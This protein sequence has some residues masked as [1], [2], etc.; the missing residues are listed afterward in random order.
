MGP[1][2]SAHLLEPGAERRQPLGP[3]FLAES[4]SRS[5]G[6]GSVNDVCSDSCP[7]EPHFSV[8]K[9]WRT[10][11]GAD[12][13]VPAHRLV[14][15]SQLATVLVDPPRAFAQQIATIR[16]LARI[17]AIEATE[18][19]EQQL[20]E[21]KRKLVSFTPAGHFAKNRKRI[22]PMS[23]T[24]CTSLDID[25]I[26]S[27]GDINHITVKAPL[28]FQLPGTRLVFTSPSGNGVKAIVALDPVPTTAAEFEAATGQLRVVAQRL[29][30]SVFVDANVD[31]LLDAQRI[32]YMSHDLQP[33]VDLDAEPFHWDKNFVPEATGKIANTSDIAPIDAAARALEWM[34][35]LSNLRH[36]DNRMAQAIR[37]ASYMAHH[38]ILKAHASLF[39]DAVAQS[40][41][42][43]AEIER[44][45]A[46]AYSYAS[47]IQQLTQQ[48][49]EDS[50]KAMQQPEGHA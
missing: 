47:G 40:G 36:G 50:A 17:H 15:L 48:E 28:L 25:G 1:Q 31:R 13:I 38:G 41:I 2:L 24:G 19:T 10:P 32:C 9:H 6:G 39:V 14:T 35:E 11:K 22:D 37:C 42:K 46:N 18:E 20:I 8:F 12:V 27:D 4:S 3:S 16:E 29:L 33:G 30:K 44:V 7:S 5:H 34:E 26:V 49:I 23:F 45:C 43:R 21:A